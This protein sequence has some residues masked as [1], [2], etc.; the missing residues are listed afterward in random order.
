MTQLSHSDAA[1]ILRSIAERPD[2][3]LYVSNAS[4][5]VP[6]E[7]CS[8]R[9][10]CLLADD[11]TDRVGRFFVVDVV[12]KHDIHGHDWTE[13]RISS[14]V[15]GMM[16]VSQTSLRGFIEIERTWEKKDGG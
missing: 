9:M 4:R 8:C 5:A 2:E 15:R 16:T 7:P 14:P 13:Y 6:T 10:L 12:T 11:Y 3:Y 1:F